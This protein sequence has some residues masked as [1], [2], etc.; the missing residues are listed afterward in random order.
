MPITVLAM[1]VLVGCAGTSEPADGGAQMDAATIDAATIDAPADAPSSTDAAL[2]ASDAEHDASDADHDAAI[3]LDASPSDAGPLDGGIVRTEDPPTHPSRPPIAPFA[4]CTVTT[5]HDTIAGA[6]H[7]A[8]CAPIAYPHHPPSAG[9]H[10]G[11]WADFGT[12]TAPIPWGF[13]VHA[14]EHGA[15]VLAHHCEDD[16]D[17][18]AVRAEYAAL[19]ADHG[20][21][22]ACRIEDDLS[23]FIVVPD[24]TLPVPIAAIAWEEVYLA[25]C[26]DPPSLRAFVAAHYATAPEDFCAAGV[27]RSATGWCP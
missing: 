20:H 13:L 9:A 16:A 1:T 21:D 5:A 12:Y 10:F 11:Q 6:E 18:D 15:I 4:E 14:M 8:A 23:R 24:P 19:I 22:P 17:C 26:L 3:A 7:T 27:D 2:D 25:T